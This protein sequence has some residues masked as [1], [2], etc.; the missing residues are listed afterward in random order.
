MRT[1]FEADDDCGAPEVIF[2]GERDVRARKQH[3]CDHCGRAIEPGT[4]YVRRAW[5][6]DGEMRVEKSHT[7]AGYCIGPTEAEQEAWARLDEADALSASV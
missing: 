4:K 6:V 1:P 7:G 3:T 5:R 2:L